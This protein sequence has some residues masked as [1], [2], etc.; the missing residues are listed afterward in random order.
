M[1][2]QKGAKVGLCE[3]PFD[4]V[5]SATA[6]GLGGTC[7]IRGCVPKKLLVYGSEFSADFEDAR[8]FGWSLPER[9]SFNWDYL[10]KAK[11]EEVTRLNGIYAKLLETAG[12]QLYTG[13]GRLLN[14]NTIQITTPQVCKKY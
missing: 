3:L 8:G 7:V 1:A 4:P 6:G 2:T 13:A 10:L 12:V 11:T 14:A 5:S 9:P